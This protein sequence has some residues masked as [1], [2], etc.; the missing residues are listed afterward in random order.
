M[1]LVII[2]SAQGSCQGRRE[3]LLHGCCRICNTCWTVEQK[4]ENGF[5]QIDK[6]LLQG[7]TADETPVGADASNFLPGPVLAFAGRRDALCVL[8]TPYLAKA[9]ACKEAPTDAAYRV[10][11]IL[12]DLSLAAHAL[13]AAKRAP[14]WEW[15]LPLC[16][17]LPF[18]MPFC[19]PVCYIA[20]TA[21]PA[22]GF[23]K[24]LQMRYSPLAIESCTGWITS[25]ARA[26][27]PIRFTM[28]FGGR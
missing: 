17:M 11:A 9:A 24:K 4:K 28:A 14:V 16:T 18:S 10:R 27:S 5:A 6:C 19:P 26:V 23:L 22:P 15:I 3:R 2:G 21:R 12:L 25:S 13:A 1:P 20:L 7:S 8:Y